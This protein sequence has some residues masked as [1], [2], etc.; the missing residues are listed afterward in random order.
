[1]GV[2]GLLGYLKERSSENFDEYKLHRS[3]VV[4]DGN[5]VLYALYNNSDL[6]TQFDGEFLAFEAQIECLIT[7]MRKCAIDPI[8]VFDG[9]PDVSNALYLGIFISVTLP[10]E[11]AVICLIHWLSCISP[12][13]VHRMRR[14]YM[15]ILQWQQLDIGS[16]KKAQIVVM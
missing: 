1:M 15:L 12:L 4:L 2:K 5:N 13:M 16:S 9:I 11:V 10:S 8:F 3:Q 14:S 6:L 7:E